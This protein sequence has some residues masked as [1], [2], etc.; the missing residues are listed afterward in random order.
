MVALAA[1]VVLPRS[2]TAEVSFTPEQTSGSSLG[3]ALGGVGERL[4]SL[5]GLSGAVPSALSGGGAGSP[6]FFGAVLRS[7]ELL[8]STL[9]APYADPERPSERRTLLELL[10]PRGKTA[11]RRLGN[12][13]RKLAKKVTITMD[14]RS[15]IVTLAVT[16]QDAQLAAEVANRMA[17]LLNV[18]NLERRQSSSREQRRFVEARLARAEAEL[19]EAE[20]ARTAFLGAN[21]GFQGSPLLAESAFRLAREVAARE[22]LVVTLRQSFEDARIA[23]VRDTPVLSIVDRA[24][25]PDRQSSP[26]PVLWASFGAVLGLAA[27]AAAVVGA[28]RWPRGAGAARAVPATGEADDL[29]RGAAPGASGEEHRGGM[30]TTTLR[31]SDGS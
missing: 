25:P 18:Y 14:R 17:A 12:A 19:R 11:A 22:D 3:T 10:R 26:R 28:A 23:E 9:T 29:P 27:A 20:R 4:G 21:R 31:P 15:G 7:R 8:E 2:Y 1:A 13:R 6:E 24:A 16:L 30:W 5:A